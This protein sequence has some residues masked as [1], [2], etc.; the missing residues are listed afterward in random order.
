[1]QNQGD[2]TLLLV[3][4]GILSL[5]VY[6]AFVA[7]N[8]ISRLILLLIL[9]ILGFLAIIVGIYFFSSWGRQNLKR[10]KRLKE[11][12]SD[13]KNSSNRSVLMGLDVDLDENIFLPDSVRTRH[14]HV[15]G[16]TGS[17]KTESVILNFLKQDIDRNLGGI[18][19]D[20][21][22]DSSFLKYLKAWV[23]EPKL[24]VFDLTDPESQ[25]YDPLAMGSPLEAAQRLFASLIWSEEYYQ[26]KAISVLQRI[27]QTWFEINGKNPTLSEISSILETPDSFSSFLGSSEVPASTILR[28]FQDTSGLKDQIKS[29]TLGHLGKTLSPKFVSG[30]QLADAALGAVIY[31]RLQK[32]FHKKQ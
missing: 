30:I 20:A 2:T 14:V 12:P 4:F 24:F 15:L 5:L 22:G 8:P 26:S 27:F 17:G 13:I 18:I 29:L 31:F 10:K 19:L 32:R 9:C 16:A 7:L 21:K 6:Q 25:A 3:P 11:I 23:P 28:E 1:M